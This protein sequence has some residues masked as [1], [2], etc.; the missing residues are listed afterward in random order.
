MSNLFD[1]VLVERDA[2]AEGASCIYKPTTNAIVM[3]CQVSNSHYGA[4]PVKLFIKR[5]AVITPLASDRIE[6]CRALDVVSGKKVALQAGDEVLIEA[7]RGG[8]FS[9]VTTAYRDEA[10]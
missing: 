7:V 2:I 8:V 1:S 5:G 6:G 10:Q 9:V 4:L 3:S